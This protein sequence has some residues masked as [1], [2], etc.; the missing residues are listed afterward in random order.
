MDFPDKQ[1]FST[2]KNQYVEN[3]QKKNSPLQKKA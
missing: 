2:Q 1:K 3:S